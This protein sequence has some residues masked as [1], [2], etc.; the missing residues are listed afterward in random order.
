MVSRAHTKLH[1]ECARTLACRC[2]MRRTCKVEHANIEYASRLLQS[3]LHVT[4]S[5]FM[6]SQHLASPSLCIPIVFC[7]QK[8]CVICKRHVDII[9]INSLSSQPLCIK[10]L[11]LRDMNSSR[12][13]KKKP[14]FPQSNRPKDQNPTPRHK[15]MK[16]YCSTQAGL[17]TRCLIINYISLV[18]FGNKK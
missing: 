5:S 10:L 9:L 3:S 6:Q 16:A 11:I 15:P 13:K 18:M 8:L 4:K 12:K 7:I 1:R 17:A 2:S 14:Q